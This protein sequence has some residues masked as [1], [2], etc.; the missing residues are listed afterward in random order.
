MN[1]VLVTLL[2]AAGIS[3]VKYPCFIDATPTMLENST[4][5]IA[6]LALKE[7]FTEDMLNAIQKLDTF[8]SI[9]DYEEDPNSEYLVVFLY[10]KPEWMED[11][12]HLYSGRPSKISDEFVEMLVEANPD[13]SDELRNTKGQDATSEEIEEHN[14][15]VNKNL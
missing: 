3:I 10:Y 4:P 1:P 13:F 11:V 14:K 15:N 9:S 6:A 7:Y 5:V 2:P 8:K 12:F